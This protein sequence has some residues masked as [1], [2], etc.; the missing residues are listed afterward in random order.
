MS[1]IQDLIQE[2]IDTVY[3]LRATSLSTGKHEGQCGEFLV[4]THAAVA[5]GAWL[6]YDILITLGQEMKYIWRYVNTVPCPSYRPV[7][8]ENVR[9]PLTPVD[10]IYVFVRYYSLAWFFINSYG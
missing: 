3:F 4:L 5:A 8:F 6:M 1:S 9:L 2:L 7:I 10:W